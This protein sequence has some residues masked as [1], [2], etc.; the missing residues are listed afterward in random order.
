LGGTFRLAIGSALPLL[1]AL[2]PER[3]ARSCRVPHQEAD[4]DAGDGGAARGSA[5]RTT[6]AWGVNGGQ[7][8]NWALAGVDDNLTLT[9]GITE[10]VALFLP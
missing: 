9:R 8:A 7:G 6:P 1:A 10:P 3:R 4:R 5:G 2:A